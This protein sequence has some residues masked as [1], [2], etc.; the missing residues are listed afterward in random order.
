MNSSNYFRESSAQKRAICLKKGG[1]SFDGNFHFGRE[2]SAYS[3]CRDN[4]KFHKP[5]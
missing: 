5:K 4:I 1:R 3:H 2:T